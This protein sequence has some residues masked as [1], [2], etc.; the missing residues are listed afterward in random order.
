MLRT[1]ILLAF[2]AL[3]LVSC[4]DEIDLEVPKN[5]QKGLVIRGELLKG[6]P[7]IVRVNI[8]SLFTFDASSLGLVSISSVTLIDEAGNEMP[9]ESRSVR[10]F[11]H[12]FT[13]ADPISIDYFQSYKLRVITAEGARYESAYEELLPLPEGEV[14]LKYE[15]SI[16]ERI[17]DDGVL[18][19]RDAV[20]FFAN[21][22]L[23][24]PNSD[25]NAQ[26]LWN[27]E[28]TYQLT[29][30]AEVNI[31]TVFSKVCYLTVGLDFDNIHVL[32][33]TDL[34][35][36][37]AVDFPLSKVQLTHEFAEGYYYTVY[38]KSLNEGAY[39]YW[40]Q[41]KQAVERQGQ[42]FEPIIGRVQ[43]NLVNL[44]NKEDNTIFGYFSAH[45]QDTIRL[46]VA[47]EFNVSRLCP[48]PPAPFVPPCPS[49]FPI[50]CDCSQQDGSTTV[51]PD[52]WEF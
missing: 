41:T 52:F 9:I 47:P 31:P 32:D 12:I 14:T 51:K 6:E 8:S 17:T 20:Q 25:K 5:T 10:L 38:R 46:Y 1:L 42:L 18:I 3:V 16:I 50:C 22:S 35:E 11:E 4:L 30:S 43:S 33:G 27:A 48:L 34:A 26:L 24:I 49:P 7:S 19:Q 39:R 15:P 28:R 37:Q 36:G 44:D 23:D 45:A 21:T 2:S 13:D 40:S 29:D